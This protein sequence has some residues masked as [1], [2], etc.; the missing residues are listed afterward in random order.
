MWYPGLI[1][2]GGAFRRGTLQ[3]IISVA[4]ED[5]HQIWVHVSV[6]GRKGAH[7]YYLPD[8]EELKRVK[9]DFIGT[10]KWAYQVFPDEKHYINQHPCVL[11]LF[12]LLENKP[13]LPDFTGGTGSI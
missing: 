13:A 12:S 10:D 3:V 1:L 5:D 11:H 8:F 7:S 2:D 6:C 4:Y 9:N